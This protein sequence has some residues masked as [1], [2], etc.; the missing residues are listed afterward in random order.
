LI[1]GS[2]FC[3]E[4]CGTAVLAADRKSLEQAKANQLSRLLAT[5]M[6]HDYI[7]YVVKTGV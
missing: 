1:I 2:V 7:H 4:H 6:G 5:F 3:H